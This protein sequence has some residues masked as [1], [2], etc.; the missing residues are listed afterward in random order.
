MPKAK[1]KIEKGNIS[2]HTENILP[3]IKKWLYSDRDI[4]LRELVSNAHDAIAKLQHLTLTREFEGERDYK[5]TVKLDTEK[6]TLTISDN[7]IGMTADEVKKYI[8]QVAF[9][10]AEEFAKKYE[11]GD[12]KSQLIGHFGLGFYSAFMVADKVEIVTLSYKESSEAVKWSSTGTTEFE[13]S[14]TE[15]AEGGTDIILHL[16]EDSSDFNSEYQIRETLKKYCSFIPVPITFNDAQVNEQ[17]P[18]WV[19]SPTSLKDQDYLDFYKYLFPFSDEPLFWIHINIDFPINLSGI[20]YFPKLKHQFDS[21]QK[22]IKLYCNKVYVSD[23]CQD[24]IPEF[25]TVLQGVIDAPDIPLNVSRSFLQNDPNVRKLAEHI[26]KKVADKLKELHKK[27]RAKFEQNWEEINPFVKFGAI[28]N[29]KFYEQAKDFLIFKSTEDYYT[30][31]EDYLERNKEKHEKKIFYISDEIAQSSYLELFKKEG[32]EAIF[33]NSVI[34]SHFIQHLEMKH[35]GVQFQRIDSDVSEHLVD[36]DKTEIVDAKTNKTASQTIEEVFKKNLTLEGLTVKV[37]SLKS[38]EL[39]GMIVLSEQMRRLKE[40]SAMYQQG[41]NG[42]DLMK[43]H[44]LVVNANSKVA[45]LIKTKAEILPEGED[46]KMLCEHIYDLAMLSQG[47][48]ENTKMPIFV[49]RSTKILGMVK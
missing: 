25:L 18:I 17:K 6:K 20:L 8:N 46:V 32:L 26:Q 15:K 27:D 9:S 38:E 47:L 28:S 1:A 10:G 4:F 2:V 31:I 39:A 7:G 43:E 21:S 5:I 24:L 35:A 45:K 3:I 40:M 11:G 44:T 22:H 41:N 19:S 13:I 14:T 16:T 30:T 33:L 23:N 37:E 42:M 36:K 29:D 12:Q 48:L 34:D 49:E